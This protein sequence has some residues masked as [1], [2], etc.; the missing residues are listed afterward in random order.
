MRTIYALFGA[1]VQRRREFVTKLDQML[2]AVFEEKVSD[3]L[4]ICG[5]ATNP[6]KQG[7]GYGRTLVQFINALVGPLFSLCGAC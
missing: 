3:M 1:F 5:L 7:K 4:E 6:L 2:D